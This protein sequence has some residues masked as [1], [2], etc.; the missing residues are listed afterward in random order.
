MVEVTIEVT[1]F[2]EWHCIECS[3]NASPEGKHLPLKEITGFLRKISEDTFIDRINISGGEPLAHPDIYKILKLCNSMAPTWVYTNEIRNLIYNANTINEV[4]VHAN[5]CI[6]PGTS[7]Y[8]PKGV[9]RVHLLKMVK[10]GRALTNNLPDTNVT[11]SHNFDRE[12][13][14]C[15]HCKHIL[16]QADGTIVNAPCEKMYECRKSDPE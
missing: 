13:L 1:Q 4:H 7:V 8:I 6:V 5:V 11:V 12:G 9:E 15:S 2:C 10:T 14:D 3:S 16:L